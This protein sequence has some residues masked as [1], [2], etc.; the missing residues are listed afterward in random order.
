MPETSLRFLVD[1]CVGPTVAKW[2]RTQGY[3]V[4]SIYDEARG[5]DD[6][7]IITIAVIERRIIITADKDFGRKIY[8]NRRIHYGVVLLRL[9]DQRTH[10]MIAA[11]TRLLE[12]YGEQIVGQFVVVTDKQVRFGHI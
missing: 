12:Q 5:I 8:M 4:I 3:D 2:L 7:T 6:D 1:E 9:N 11:L 10:S